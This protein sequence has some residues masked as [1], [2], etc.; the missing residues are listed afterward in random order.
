M[1]IKTS[2]PTKLSCDNQ[3]AMHIASN[4]IFHEQAKH[5]DIDCHLVHE[6]IQLGLISTEYV[7][8][9]EQLGDSF[10]NL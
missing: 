3:A 5:I 2:V 6:R 9:R 1:G 4:P 7:K 8:T 10:T